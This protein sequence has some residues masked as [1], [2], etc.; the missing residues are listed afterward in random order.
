MDPDK[1]LEKM[2]LAL[3]R[4]VE[5][6]RLREQIMFLQLVASSYR[7]C[8][9]ELTKKLVE[10]SMTI[11]LFFELKIHYLLFSFAFCFINYWLCLSLGSY[12]CDLEIAL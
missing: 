3:E 2:K 9:A 6:N 12:E 11:F 4:E 1:E 8:D 10:V 7:R 5:E